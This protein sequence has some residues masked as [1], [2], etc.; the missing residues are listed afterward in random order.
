MAS[1]WSYVMVNSPARIFWAER[2]PIKE[3]I[4]VSVRI[5]DLR[6]SSKTFAW[7]SHRVTLAQGLAGKS[8]ARR[9]NGDDL[10]FTSVSHSGNFRFYHLLS[11]SPKADDLS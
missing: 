8:S 11:Q 4:V 2:S 1:F 3:I 5:G 10:H 9:S 7:G 6:T